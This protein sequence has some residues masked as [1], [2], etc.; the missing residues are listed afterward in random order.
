MQKT[1]GGDSLVVNGVCTTAETKKM[2]VGFAG[3]ALRV[4]RLHS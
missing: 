3:V 1:E 4:N 2:Y